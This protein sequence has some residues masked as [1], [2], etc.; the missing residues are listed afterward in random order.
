MQIPQ[1]MM[2]I[3]LGA[4][5][6]KMHDVKYVAAMLSPNFARALRMLGLKFNEVQSVSL[7]WE[8]VGNPEYFY[9][10]K[11][12]FIDEKKIAALIPDRVTGYNGKNR[13]VMG[14]YIDYLY[15]LVDQAASS[16][17]PIA[18][19]EASKTLESISKPRAYIAK[20]SDMYEQTRVLSKN[21]RNLILKGTFNGL[22]S[23]FPN[24]TSFRRAS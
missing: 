2:M 9:D 19:Y 7:D 14:E 8:R 6:A 11:N 22:L 21:W 18:A 23:K 4:T 13:P 3:Q 24:I 20:T 12:Y 1:I 17:D 5:D 10:H 16:Q 15:Y